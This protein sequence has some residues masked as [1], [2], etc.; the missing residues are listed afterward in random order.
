VYKM[1]YV[2][3]ADDP[4]HHHESY[5]EPATMADFVKEDYWYR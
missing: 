1:R 5:K 3:P 4:H 2:G